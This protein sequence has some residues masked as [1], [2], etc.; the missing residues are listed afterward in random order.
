MTA[1]SPAPSIPAGSHVCSH[2]PLHAPW[3][4]SPATYVISVQG[5]SPTPFDRNF[6]TKMGAKAMNWM[7][8]KIKESYRN[9]RW[10]G[11][12][13][14]SRG[15]W[16]CG[17]QLTATLAVGRIFANTPDS[18]CVLGM[19]KRALVFQPVTELKDQTDFE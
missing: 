9:G 13:A 5:G 2:V 16:S 14:P 6:A 15:A 17:A 12:D 1:S 3:S 19:R 10:H 4:S 11:V 7:S 8:G 18:G